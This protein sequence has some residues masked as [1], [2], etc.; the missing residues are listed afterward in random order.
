VKRMADDLKRYQA[1]LIKSAKLAAIGEMASEIS[2][3]IQNRISGVSLWAQYL[4][5]ELDKDD[6][7]REY[8]E[9]M[10]QGLDGFLGL[11]QDLK[12]FYKT[13]ILQL[14]DVNLNDLVKASLVHIERQARD[15]GIEV[16][17]HLDPGLPVLKCDGEKIKSVIVNLLINAIEAVS[18]RSQIEIETCTESQPD[19]RTVVFLVKDDGCGIAQEDLMRIF[20]PFYSTKGGGGGLGL[21]IASNLVSAHG[22]KIEVESSPGCGATFKVILNVN[23]NGKDTSA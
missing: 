11:L 8:L 15:R 18:D 19:G 6:P 13:P 22:G 4:D 5:N 2:H 16:A 9:E 10:K 12:Q 20:Y 23:E 3:E 7:K 21:A 14:S 1:E 17:Q